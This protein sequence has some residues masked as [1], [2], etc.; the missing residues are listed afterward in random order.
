[1]P[2]NSIKEYKKK[3]RKEYCIKNKDK[4]AKYY[5][6]YWKKRKSIE[7]K[8]GKGAYKKIQFKRR[9]ENG[10][11]FLSGRNSKYILKGKFLQKK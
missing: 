10:E 9:L 7:E 3:Y 11:V 2:R 4:I 8:G 5:K 1:M 6:E